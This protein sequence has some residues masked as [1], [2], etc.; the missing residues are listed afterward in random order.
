MLRGLAVLLVI[1]DHSPCGRFCLAGWIGV[2]LFFVL[3]G[4]LISGLLFK[5][6]QLNDSISTWRFLLRRGMKIYPGFYAF[7]ALTTLMHPA[8]VGPRLL[9]EAVFI[10]NYMPHY[11][12]HT[13]SLAVE[14]HFYIALPILLC[15]LD[16][17]RLEWIPKIAFCAMIA[18]AVMRIRCSLEGASTDQIMYPTHLRFDAL[19]FGVCLSY[20]YVYSAAPILS[21]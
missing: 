3:S 16:K 19:L 21:N 8:F 17:K 20:Y 11:W 9:N 14:E 7:L 12:G 5:E 15:L 10:Q 1:V 6:F 4:F 2:D 18:C 13:W